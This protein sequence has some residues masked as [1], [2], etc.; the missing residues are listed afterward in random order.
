MENNFNNG[1]SPEEESKASRLNQARNAAKLA[2]DVTSA[3]VAKNPKAI[4]SLGARFAKYW[5]VLAMAAVFDLFAIIPYL[6]VV[7]NLC[8]GLVLF[9][10]FGP[11]KLTASFIT[12][13]VGSVFDFFVGVLPINLAATVA[14]IVIKE[15]G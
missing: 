7:I 3:V 2:K 14:R 15:I 13:G 6:S 8:F 10:Y 11:K 5:P 9:L 12:L 4:L 1:I